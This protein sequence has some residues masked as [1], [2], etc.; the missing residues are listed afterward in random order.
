MFTSKFVAS[1]YR[2]KKGGIAILA[3]GAIAFGAVFTGVSINLGHIY[4]QKR[5]FQGIT[6]LAAMSAA[7]NIDRYRDAAIATFQENPQTKDDNIATIVS[8]KAGVY[9]ADASL[10][11]ANRFRDAL[12]GESN[13]AAQITYKKQ[14]PLFFGKI[15]GMEHITLETTAIAATSKMA[16]LMIGTR[17]MSFDSAR[18]N[19]N[20][21]S[22]LGTSLSWSFMDYESLFNFNFNIFDLTQKL[23]AQYKY[24]GLS[25]DQ[26]M[27]S[28]FKLADVYSALYDVSRTAPGAS[29]TTI[30]ALSQLK[31]QTISSSKTV[32]LGSVFNPGPLKGLSGS[33]KPLIGASVNAMDLISSTVQIANGSNAIKIESGYSFPWSKYTF[34]YA[35]GEKPQGQSS[36]IIGQKGSSAHSAQMRLLVK[37][38][39]SVGG[40][41]TNYGYYYEQAGST[42]VI[43]NI[44]CVAGDPSKNVVTV[45]AYPGLFD[46]WLADVSVKDFENTK[47]AVSPAPLKVVDY[48]NFQ[49]TMRNHVK[50]GNNTPTTL[51][52]TASD[53]KNRVKK[54]TK[55]TE[56]IS[57]YYQSLF[58]DYEYS[59]VLNGVDLTASWSAW[60]KSL[61]A[62]YAG[63]GAVLD[64]GINAA[65][66][67]S[68]LNYGEADI[69]VTDVR[70]DGAVLVR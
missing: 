9:D 68:G 53:I 56:F 1:F 27:K 32:Q 13:N 33:D 64:A 16:T 51:T 36:I 4:L 28:E 31:D 6:D 39:N 58:S 38:E 14:V 50:F 21:N 12:S 5:T 8:A 10:S 17:Y 44:Q 59:V 46:M 61:A 29:T 18:L 69:W 19:I 54:S 43:R 15:V 67:A 55:T 47:Y 24:S 57:S 37:L 66:N 20:L 62:V 3:S 63:Y 40:Y 22:A 49:V 65:L 70:C 2:N 45:D 34:R 41:N 30:N 35:L 23:A 52:F 11:T 26:F 48:P 60:V 25:Y 42:A 7:E